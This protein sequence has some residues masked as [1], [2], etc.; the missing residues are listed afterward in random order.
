M[1]NQR[2]LNNKF[3]FKGSFTFRIINEN[4]STPDYTSLS[5]NYQNFIN[6]HEIQSNKQKKFNGEGNFHLNEDQIG[7]EESMYSNNL[8]N[9]KTAPSSSFSS[10]SDILNNALNQGKLKKPKLIKIWVIFLLEPVLPIV[11]WSQH[12]EQVAHRNDQKTCDITKCYYAG[13]HFLAVVIFSFIYRT[14]AGN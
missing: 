7:Y 13:L 6:Q 11:C 14:Y 4:K 2:C 9:C 3:K 1:E 8:Q 5:N 10:A 12:P